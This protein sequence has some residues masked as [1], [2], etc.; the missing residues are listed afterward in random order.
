MCCQRSGYTVKFLYF[1][2]QSFLALVNPSLHIANQILTAL[3]H[4]KDDLLLCRG[5]YFGNYTHNQKLFTLQ[6]RNMLLG[7]MPT[8][9]TFQNGPNSVWRSIQTPVQLF[10]QYF[11][12]LVTALPSTISV[13]NRTDVS[14]QILQN[15]YD[16]FKPC[17]KSNKA[18]LTKY[19][20]ST[21]QLGNYGLFYQNDISLFYANWW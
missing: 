5:I 12:N 19:Q 11:W 2:Q 10:C 15:S 9:H 14:S 13:K 1:T 4:R 8:Q 16:Y 18:Y 7:K 20:N 3:L 17:F 6:E 21:A